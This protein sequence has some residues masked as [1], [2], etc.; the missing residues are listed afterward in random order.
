MRKRERKKLRAVL[1]VNR[2]LKG[3]PYFARLCIGP[4]NCALPLRSDLKPYQA[5]AIAHRQI[6]ALLFEAYDQLTGGTHD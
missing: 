5:S 3:G 6:T 1:S 2:P 4:L